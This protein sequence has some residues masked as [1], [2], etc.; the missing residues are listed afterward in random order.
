MKN[1]KRQ[2]VRP[3]PTVHIARR[4]R[5]QVLMSMILTVLWSSKLT[6]NND[7]DGHNYDDILRKEKGPR[8]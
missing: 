2:H 8:F 1:V 4:K 6:S 5:P 7:N 3:R